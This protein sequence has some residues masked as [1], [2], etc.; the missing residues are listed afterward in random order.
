MPDK[1]QLLKATL[2]RHSLLPAK[3]MEKK[4]KL[5]ET[6]F[7]HFPIVVVSIVVMLHIVIVI[8]IPFLVKIIESMK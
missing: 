3:I 5:L 1:Q 6:H 4:N 2:S 7:R 8:Y